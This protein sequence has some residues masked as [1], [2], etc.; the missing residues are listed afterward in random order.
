[1]AKVFLMRSQEW[2]HTKRVYGALE[3]DFDVK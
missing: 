1:M 3:V 2:S